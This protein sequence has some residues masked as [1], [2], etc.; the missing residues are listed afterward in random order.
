MR[1]SI[2]FTEK[3]HRSIIKSGEVSLNTAMSRLKRLKKKC[4][5]FQFYKIDSVYY[6]SM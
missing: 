1:L 3:Y 4:L 6:S 5:L 2:Y